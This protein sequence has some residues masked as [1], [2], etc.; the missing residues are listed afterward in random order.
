MVL[1]LFLCKDSQ[2][3]SCF[4]ARR[5]SGESR[6]FCRCFCGHGRCGIYCAGSQIEKN[7]A[8]CLPSFVKWTTDSLDQQVCQPNQAKACCAVQVSLPGCRCVTCKGGTANK[9]EADTAFSHARGPKRGIG[10]DRAC[11]ETIRVP[12]RSLGVEGQH[13]RLRAAFSQAFR[14]SCC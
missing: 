13:Y 7:T 12:I 2:S 9:A 4:S 1:A 11:S 5:S 8:F 6:N 10:H 14:P 3:G